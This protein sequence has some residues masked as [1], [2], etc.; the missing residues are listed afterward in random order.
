LYRLSA[1]SRSLRGF[2]IEKLVELTALAAAKAAS[3]A[4]S[5]EANGAT[6]PQNP[7]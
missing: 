4:A 3:W 5:A 7:G 2:L 1:Q 6:G